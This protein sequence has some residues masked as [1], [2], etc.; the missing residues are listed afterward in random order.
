MKTTK[1]SALTIG[2]A[3]ALSA[4]MARAEC[5]EVSITEM[6]WGSAAVVTS[7]SKFLM[8]QGYGCRVTVVPSST[9]PSVTSIA[10]TGK[11]DIVTELWV[12]TAPSY[13]DLEK[14]GK[15][16][17]VAD[18]LS[19]GGVEAFWIPKYLA[20]EHPELTTM[21]GVLAH[22]ELVGGRFNNCPDGWACRV[23]NDNLA[24]A[25]DFAG[26][27]LEVFN[28]GSSETLA[29]S[30]ASAYESKEPWFGY[31]FAPT[32]VLGKYEMVMVDMGPYVADIHACNSAADCANPGK[33]AYPSARVVTGVTTDF[34]EREPEVADLMSK[35][36]FTNA[37]MNG[38]LAWQEDN[39]ASAEEAAVHFLTTY[40]DVWGTW[41]NDAAQ[42]KLAALLQ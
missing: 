32:S 8:E 42:E 18:V 40:K 19:D 10:E 5:G 41:L 7:V 36:A 12:N 25:W 39:K 21:D 20:D 11:P 17:T 15:V 23:V 33:S 2:A 29:A 34:A 13:T 1:L 35:V 9:L 22:P 31:Y 26:H 14:A 4:G 37:Q 28:H 24:K 16:K 6:N 27:G 30:I 38:V 3:L